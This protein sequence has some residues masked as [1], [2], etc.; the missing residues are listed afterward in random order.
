MFSK[1]SAFF[2]ILFLLPSLIFAQGEKCLASQKLKAALEQNPGLEQILELQERQTREFIANFK[3]L[4]SR[5]IITIP[6]VVHVVWNKEE[7]NISDEQILSQIDILNKDFRN[8]NPASAQIPDEFT[9]LIADP[10]IEFC[11]ASQDPDGLPT[12]GITRT[13]TEFPFIVD[14][15]APGNRRRLKHDELGG[16]SSWDTKSYLNIWI[17]KY[18]PGTLGEGC[19]PNVCSPDEDGIIVDPFVFGTTGTAADNAPNNMGRTTTHEVG[20]YLNLSHIWGSELGSCVK[21]DFVEDTPPQFFPSDGCPNH[22]KN[23]CQTNDLFMNYMD[24]TDDA[25]MGIFT[26]GQK[27]RML[28][29]LNGPRQRLLFSNGCATPTSTQNALLEGKILLF[30][31]PT[32]DIVNLQLNFTATGELTLSLINTLGQ[33]LQ[34]FKTPSNSNIQLSLSNYP[35]GM[36]F[37]QIA[38]KGRIQ[39]KRI[40]ISDW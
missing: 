12:N 29:A 26:K 18:T 25:C 23:T 9:D 7:E 11:L 17:G 38:A 16:K 33:T 21:D 8:D 14:E 32:R 31:N 1:K 19:F 24:Y 20:H 36:Y 10:E 13:Q 30:P 6:V 27:M 40:I 4:Q 39:S 5:S 3:P 2:L 22:P 28:S 15:Y 34:Q 37:I 35:K